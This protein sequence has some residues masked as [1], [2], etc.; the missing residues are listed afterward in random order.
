MSEVL[1]AQEETCRRY[2]VAPVAPSGV[3][4]LG[5]AIGSLE[6]LP[7]NALRHRPAPGM[8]GWYVWGGEELSTDPGF[9]SPLHLSHIES[10]AAHLVPYLALPPGWRVLL[11]PGQEDAWFDET[12]LEHEG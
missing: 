11:A 3:E 5:I 8:S 7:L 2:S 12:L 10:Y 4:K 1:A 6:K 9:F